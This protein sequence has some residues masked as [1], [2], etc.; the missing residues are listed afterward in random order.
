MRELKLLQ[1]NVQK[2]KDKVM[3]PFFEDQEV[4]SYDIIAIQE[5]WQNPFI[6]STYN[7]A[8][9]GFHLA[10]PP[11]GGRACLFINKRLDFSSW[12][13][14][15]HTGDLCTATIRATDITVHV[16][17][18][19]NE[20]PATHRATADGTPIALL[21]DILQTPGEHV[22]LGDFNLHHPQWNTT[23]DLT[24]HDMA[25]ALIE[26]LEHAGVSLVTPK[27]VTTWE[28]R[29]S[30]STIDL[31]FASNRLHGR[32]T[33]CKTRSDL[34]QGSDHYPISTRIEVGTVVQLAPRRRNWKIMDREKVE[35]RAQD[36]L[37]LTGEDPASLEAYTQYL[38]RFVQNLI[39]ETTPWSRPSRRAA[40]WWTDEIRELVL[41]TRRL[42]RTASLTQ[43]AEDVDA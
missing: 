18:V 26:N 19:Y 2:S 33:E 22:I 40:P 23:V 39:E 27:G 3:A 38:T 15:F 36:L 20:P 16:H 21:P 25:D 10:F 34:E 1:Y 31:C 41:E 7:S 14:E 42:R 32:I 11:E 35:Q 13:V 37:P 6:N 24:R 28:A 17:N 4:Q 30:R 43:A 12:T 5:P 9:A 29:G 8:L